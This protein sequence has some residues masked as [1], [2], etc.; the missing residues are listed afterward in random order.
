MPSAVRHQLIY[1]KG[2]M[3]FS[4]HHPLFLKKEN[5]G[6]SRIVSVDCIGRSNG[7]SLEM[8]CVDM[9]ENRYG[10]QRYKGE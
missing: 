6:I 8:D 7:G 9:E 2:R 3:V 10:L 5:F 4:G 1:I